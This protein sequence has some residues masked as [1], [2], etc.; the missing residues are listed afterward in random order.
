MTKE[1][2]ESVSS[3]KNKS[4]WVKSFIKKATAPLIAA[5]LLASCSSSNGS[6]QPETKMI[7][8]GQW[9]TL[10]SVVKDSLWLPED[11]TSDPKLCRALIDN[12][13]SQNDIDDINMINLNDVLTINMDSLYQTIDNYQADTMWIP[14]QWK[15]NEQ[16]EV[17]ENVSYTTIHSLDEFKNSDNY[18]IKKIYK[19]NNINWKFFEALKKGYSIKF[20]NP[21]ETK[22]SKSLSLD[23]IT[24]PKE[25][26]GN[27]L[28]GKKFVLDPGHGSLDTWALGLAQYWDAANKEKVVVYESAIMMDL[29]YRIARELRAHWAKVELTHYMNRRWILDVKDIPPCSR[30]FNEQWEEVFQDI[31]NWTNQDSKWNYFNA[32]WKYLKKRAT[33]ANQYTPNLMVSLHAD[34]L[35]SWDIVDDQTKILSIKYD[36]RQGVNESKVIADQLLNNWFWYYYNG[37]LSQDVKRDTANQRLWVLKTAQSPAV[38]VEFWNISQESQA[39]ILRENTKREELAKNFAAALIKVYKK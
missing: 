7:Q 9:A 18:L 22:D 26:V 4:W 39:Y 17:I 32:D 37:K 31:W 3:T 8:I 30:V 27:E 5:A 20:L 11:V 19:D 13:A 24:K 15:N 33:I 16:R 36:E 25:V 6:T 2:H 34:M 28:S 23:E 29:A 38:L 35:R 21:R 1:T 12:I 14:D 10:S